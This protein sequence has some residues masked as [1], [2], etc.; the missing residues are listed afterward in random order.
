MFFFNLFQDRVTNIAM[1]SGAVCEELIRKFKP[2]RAGAT[3]AVAAKAAPAKAGASQ[4]VA[5]AEPG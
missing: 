1:E 4:Q 2:I 5:A 3:Q